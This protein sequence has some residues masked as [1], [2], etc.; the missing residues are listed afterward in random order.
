M[1]HTILI[2]GCSS[3]IGR[4]TA[5]RFA[6][7]G[8]NVVA[9]MRSPAPEDELA[10]LEGVL[11]LPLDV[12]DPASIERAV[13]EGIARFGRIDALVNNAGYGQYGI[14]EAL[15][16]E[17]I[18]RQF[19]V[20]LFGVMDSIRAILPHFRANGAGTIINVSS[21]AGIFGLPMMTMY[22][23][24]KFALEGFAESLSYELADQNILVKQ[25]IPHG[26]VGQTRFGE[27]S[28]GDFAHD[29]ALA[30]YNAFVTRM[31][32]TFAAMASA[33]L[34]R[35]EEV[36]ELIWQAATDGSTRLRY[37]IGSDERGFVKARR[38]LSEDDYIAFMRSYFGYGSSGG[39]D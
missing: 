17:Q 7:G 24:S 12:T 8:W 39:S 28:S 22:N 33:K 21:G 20:N 34:I 25:V 2:T 14:F 3:G 11:L 27:R 10:G 23:A 4:A 37:L 13:A 9:T 1:A 19:A 26:G 35:A 32:A 38:E 16:H 30:G 6:S 18:Q 36:A 29:P 31:G 5:R 15:T